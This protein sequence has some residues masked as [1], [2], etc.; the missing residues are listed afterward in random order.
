MVGQASP[1]GYC[2]GAHV[3]T[4]T[5]THSLTLALWALCCNK[6]EGNMNET[7]LTQGTSLRVRDSFVEAINL[8][9]LLH[10]VHIRSPL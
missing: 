2:V 5:R 6:E 8:G 7:F 3:H 9:F 10:W 1:G 4:H